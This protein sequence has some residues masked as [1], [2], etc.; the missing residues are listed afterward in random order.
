MVL[1]FFTKL[2]VIETEFSA[3]SGTRV[4]TR[5]LLWEGRFEASEKPL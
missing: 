2:T 4:P 1:S 5:G 3:D